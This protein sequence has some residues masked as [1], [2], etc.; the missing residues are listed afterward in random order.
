MGFSVSNLVFSRKD[1]EVRE[2]DSGYNS[3]LASGSTNY[4]STKEIG[5]GR[6]KTTRG[7]EKQPW[8]IGPTFNA[9]D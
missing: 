9:L 2:P 3:Q 8:T 1:D 7:L 4:S 5:K 6:N